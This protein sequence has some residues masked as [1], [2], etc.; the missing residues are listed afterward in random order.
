MSFTFSSTQEVNYLAIGACDICAVRLTHGCEH[1]DNQDYQEWLAAQVVAESG[2]VNEE[3]FITLIAFAE[4][5]DAHPA[6]VAFDLEAVTEAEQVAAEV[7]SDNQWLTSERDDSYSIPLSDIE[8][9]NAKVKKDIFT[10]DPNCKHEK[11]F[12]TY[13]GMMCRYC[14]T[15]FEARNDFEQRLVNARNPKGNGYVNWQFR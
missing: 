3:A 1:S 4:A 5:C 6:D 13:G 15:K 14:G 2:S 11:A 10:H 8:R 7:A 9:H 12:P